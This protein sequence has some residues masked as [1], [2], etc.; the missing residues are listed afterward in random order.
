MEKNSA[1]LVNNHSVKKTL[2]K[3]AAPMLIGT[4]AMNAYN[5]T[6]TF[7]I[8]RLGKIPLAAIGFTFPVIMFVSCI[9]RGLGTGAMT[10]ASHAMGQNDKIQA[11]KITTNALIMAALLGITL[12]ITGILTIKP[13]FSALGTNDQ[14]MPLVKNYM[15]IWYLGLIAITFAFVG[16]PII[17][18]TGDA[19]ASSFIICLSMVI[20]I[21]LDPIMIF[22]LLGCPPMGI[23]GAAIATI[24]SESIA[25]IGVVHLLAKRHNL[26]HFYNMSLKKR[27]SIWKEISHYAI[28]GILSYILMPISS[29]FITRVVAAYGISAVAASGAAGRIEMFAFMIPMT[30]GMS[31][32][33]FVSQNYGAMAI[34]RIKQ[35]FNFAM[36]FALAFGLI[37]MIAFYLLAPF[38]A[39]CFS[40]DTEIQQIIVQYL[41]IVSLAYG[42]ME[43]HR[44]GGFFLVGT[45]HP[46]S[47]AILNALRCIVI[48]IP[49]VL[50][51]SHLAGLKGTFIGRL[52]ADGLSGIIAITWS[53]IILKKIS[54]AKDKQNV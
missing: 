40:N 27:L 43:T 10:K 21:I 44:Y 28:P 12:A 38:M 52:L 17:L 19:K 15:T 2:I 30:I 14:V 25:G 8:S 16:N 39:R 20:N 47:A 3:M 31:L 36:T 35:A 45:G 32:V 34:D 9:A 48:I 23:K 29:A 37:I 42:L 24:I 51:G 5:L 41:R 18:G 6:D 54:K 4:I 50:I 11:Q 7:F 33:P 22:G 26:L 46:I 49:F 13:T 1:T 53:W